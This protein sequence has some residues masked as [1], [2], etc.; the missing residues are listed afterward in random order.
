MRKLASNVKGETNCELPSYGK[1][2]RSVYTS[3]PKVNLPFTNVS[4]SFVTVA[5]A[6]LISVRLSSVKIME[7]FFGWPIDDVVTDRAASSVPAIVHS[8]IL[9]P[10]LIAAFLVRKFSPGE[11]I[12]KSNQAWQDLANG[13][14]EFC[15]GYMVGFLHPILSLVLVVLLHQRLTIL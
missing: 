5:A 12:S 13:L 9:C 2:F 1:R 6:F 15:T 14:L 8:S 7:N 4:F 11:H 3:F 10:G